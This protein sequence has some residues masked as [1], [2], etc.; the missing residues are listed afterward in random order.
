MLDNYNSRL[1]KETNLKNGPSIGFNT[2]QLTSPRGDELKMARVLVRVYHFNSCLREETNVLVTRPNVSPTYFNSHPHKET[3]AIPLSA[4][5]W[6]KIISTHVSARERTPSFK[7]SLNALSVLQLTSPQGDEHKIPL[8]PQVDRNFNS[9]LRKETNMILH[10]PKFVKTISTHVSIRRRTAIQHLFP[11][12][13]N[14]STHVSVRRRTNTPCNFP[15]RLLFQLT[16]PRGDELI[17]YL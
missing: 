6:W 5:I 1:R 13:E 16:S 14:I 7:Y 15:S 4:F 17:L 12:P 11:A 10:S 3:N 8:S 9:R 2:F